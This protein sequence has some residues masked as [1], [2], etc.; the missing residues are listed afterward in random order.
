[1]S[2]ASTPTKTPIVAIVLAWIGLVP[3]LLNSDAATWQKAVIA[4][5]LL[6]ITVGMVRR[7]GGP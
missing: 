3:L 1:M 7:P 6:A 5:P 4:L 2:E